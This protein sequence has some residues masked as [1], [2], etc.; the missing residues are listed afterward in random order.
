MH[1]SAPTHTPRRYRLV[2]P[3]ALALGLTAGSLGLAPALAQTTPTTD[4]YLSEIA[5]AGGNE[6]DFVEIVAPAG[7]DLSGYTVGTVT[8]GGNVYSSEHALTLPAG[9][10][11][12]ESGV[13]VVDLPITNSVN[14]GS[15]AEG[16][17]GSSAFVLD[18]DGTVLDFPQVGGVVDGAGVTA[19][20]NVNTPEALDGVEAVPT[21]A[22][23]PSGQSIA[24]TEGSWVAGETSPG[25]LP[26]TG[27][28]EPFTR[29][30]TA[31]TE[32]EP[33]PTEPTPEP[34]DE[35]TTAPGEPIAIADIQGPGDETPYDGQVVTTHGVVTATYPT[36]GLSGYFVQTPGT[37]GEVPEPGT[38]SHG[39]FVYSSSTVDEV[40]IG[41]YVE[42]TGAASEYYGQT[43]ITVGDGG[44]V[45]LDEPVEAVKIT[46]GELPTGDAARESLEGMLIQPTGD[47]TV[48]D[49]YSTNRYGEIGLVHGTETLKQATDVHRPGPDAE[50][51]EAENQE[52][53]FVLDDGSTTDYTRSQKDVPLPYL[54]PTE[55]V[56]VGAPVTFTAPTVL[57]YGHDAWRLQPTGHLTGDTMDAL[58]PVSIE[59]TREQSPAEVGGDVA[60]SSFNVLNYFTTLGEEFPDCDYYTDREGNPTTTDYCEPRGAYD[61]ENLQRQ[62]DKIVAAIN[63]L[64]ADVLSLEEIE[65][66]AAFGKDR[67]E[68]LSTLVDALNAAAGED[69]WTFVP[70]PATVPADE[71]VIRTAFIYQAEAVTPVGE[72]RIL[73]DEVNFDNAR[74]PLAQE[75][76][77]L[78][79]EG[80]PVEDAEFL[81]IVN[82]F[83]SKG[84]GSGEGNEDIGD[85]QGAS[86][87]DRVGQAHALVDFADSLAAELGTEDVFLL[88]DFNAYTQEDPMQVFY[89]AGYVNIGAEYTEEDTYLYGGRTGSL[90]HVLA[91]PS[92]VEDL[93]GADIWNIN[94]VESIGLEYS[95][96]NGNVLDL[97]DTTPFRSSDHDPLI[98]GLDRG[99][100]EEPSP[101]PTEPGE[102]P[103]HPGKGN[104]KGHD[105]GNGKGWG[106]VKDDTH[107]GKGHGLIRR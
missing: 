45:V 60:V 83:K 88:G 8:R 47:V 101:E 90:D 69:L 50:T 76:A 28:G 87:A 100:G 56:R 59:N 102:E 99:L 98:V 55:P 104:G 40:E 62:Q 75:F 71:D 4:P 10:V 29:P 43:Q 25:E 24:L 86:N 46:E 18:T 3:A 103:T 49:T 92:L 57:G 35:P 84:S 1:G 34:T 77:P 32:P 31:D 68:A 38:P 52:R 107:P 80:A 63:G 22:T 70:S 17:Y 33:E 44:A 94:S 81:A 23:A 2:L 85:G 66:S 14:T 27:T 13:F 64:D 16:S 5:Y 61:A 48:T 93:T 42:L 11:V 78:D 6:T 58:S 65:N 36:G 82:H 67:D 37:G 74:E 20:A 21:G 19:S 95:R 105:N 106:V 41:E 15:R 73:D 12:D 7:T 54:S 53:S 72:S 30:D 39:I 89:E 26:A 9:S 96:Y 51:L 97:Y 91:S 79:A